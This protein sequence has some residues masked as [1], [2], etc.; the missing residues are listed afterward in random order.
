MKEFIVDAS[1]NF[2]K[3]I[4][5]TALESGAD[6]IIIPKEKLEEAKKLGRIKFITL[7]KDNNLSDNFTFIKIE[8]KTDEEKAAQIAKSGKK[9]KVLI[10]LNLILKHTHLFL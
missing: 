5:T 1:K 2:N 6:A 7:D 4:I 8:N 10:Y 3:V 9:A